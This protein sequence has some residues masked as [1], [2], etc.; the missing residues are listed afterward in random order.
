VAET[1]KIVSPGISKSCDVDKGS[2]KN[3]G[4]AKISTDKD[5]HE[6]GNNVEV[7][8]SDIGITDE[9][10]NRV[11]IRKSKQISTANPEVGL[12]KKL[13]TLKASK[14]NDTPSPSNR[15]SSKTRGKQKEKP[16]TSE[17]SNRLKE[18][19]YNKEDYAKSPKH[20]K[21]RKRI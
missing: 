1:E 21:K 5:M 9:E 15:S 16:R 20:S 11:T 12:E 10:N 13:Q 8:P 17:E 2:A 19:T 14:A 6:D 4:G 7:Q 18:G 3:E